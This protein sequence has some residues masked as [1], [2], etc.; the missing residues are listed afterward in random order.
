VHGLLSLQITGADG[1]QA[2]ATQTAL[3]VHASPGAQGLS[4]GV[5][6][7]PLS[8]T[9]TSSVQGLPSSQPTGT[10]GVQ[11]PLP[12]MS[13]AV[14]ALLSSQGAWLSEV[15]QPWPGSHASSVQTLPS[16]QVMGAPALHA[17][18]S[19]M[20]PTVHAFPSEQG[21]LF[22]VNVQP[23]SGAQAS[24]VQMFPSSHGSAGPPLQLP[25]SHVSLV[26]HALPSS[27][28]A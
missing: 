26:E 5:Y 7:Q 8:A 24:S 28:G 23:V 13:L 20:S 4:L 17:P 14:Q 22:A 3:A 21:A 16:S 2:P 6:V 1:T 10:P 18:P 9:Q 27:Q 11:L 15:T 19:Q 12:Q 25:P